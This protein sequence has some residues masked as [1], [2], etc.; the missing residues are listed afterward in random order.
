VLPANAA[1]F[2]KFVNDLVDF[3][4]LKPDNLIALY[5]PDET[6]ETLLFK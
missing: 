4:A 1:I 3:V 5:Y 2:L 6:L